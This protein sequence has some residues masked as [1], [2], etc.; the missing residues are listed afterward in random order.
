[1]VE[2]MCRRVQRE[3]LGQ[4]LDLTSPEAW[5]WGLSKT[6]TWAEEGKSEDACPLDVSNLQVHMKLSRIECKAGRERGS[7]G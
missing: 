7:H 5:S 6:P 3:G 2:W 4:S 1:M